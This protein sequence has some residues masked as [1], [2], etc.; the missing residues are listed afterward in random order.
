MFV[1]GDGTQYWDAENHRFTVIIGALDAVLDPEQIV[2]M[3][4]YFGTEGEKCDISF[5]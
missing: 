5:E 4:F 2:G 1:N 3:S